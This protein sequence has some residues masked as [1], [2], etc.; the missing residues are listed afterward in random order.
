MVWS[1]ALYMTQK[2][3]MNKTKIE[4]TDSTWNPIIGCSPISIGCANC[5]AKNM[6]RRFE[7]KLEIYKNLLRPNGHWNGNVNLNNNQLL[8]KFPKKPSQKYFVGSMTDMFHEN[9]PVE[10][11]EK[12]FD[13]VKN[14]PQH[15]FQFL[16][17]RADRMFD[18]FSNHDVHQNVWLGI[19]AE[20]QK[21]L[22]ERLRYLIK[23]AAPIRFISA[24]PLLGEIDFRYTG[25]LLS[26]KDINW[27][28]AGGETQ[29]KA[30]PM[31]PLW[32]RKIRDW[33]NDEEIPFLF[34]GWGEW[35]PEEVINENKFNAKDWV[36][37]GEWKMGRVGKKQMGEQNQLLDGEKHLYFPK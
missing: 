35:L 16:T 30:R 11:L 1:F 32:V 14:N 6:V 33:C 2:L 23:I 5:Y 10:W 13:I 18:Y 4:W 36:F 15:V 28:I 24:E 7:G 37:D 25:Q 12:V 8:K 29:F 27:V 9:I 21:N 19:T 26:N 31:N 3:I 20:N 17:K 34:K 22:D